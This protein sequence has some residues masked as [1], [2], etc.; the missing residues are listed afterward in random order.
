[1]NIKIMKVD[2]SDPK[3]ASEIIS[4]LNTY[5]QDPMGGGEPLSQYVI[6]N[7]VSELSK[8]PHVFSILCYVDNIAAGLINCFEEFSTFSCKPLVNVHQVTYA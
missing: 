3:Q 2:Y 4:L 7:L 6:E 8:L 1:M 5:A